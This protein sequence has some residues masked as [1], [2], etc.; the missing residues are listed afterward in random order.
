MYRIIISA[1]L[2]FAGCTS[3]V[4]EDD[5]VD[6]SVSP[7]S[8]TIEVV[9]SDCGENNG[10][11]SVDASGGTAPY[12]YILNTQVQTSN[13]FN[14]LAP[15]NYTLKVEDVNNCTFE[16][17]LQV[18]NK[19]GVIASST[20]SAAGCGTA[21]GTI[22]VS[23]SNG[24]EPYTYRFDGVSQSS[25][26]K[27][28]LEYG[29]H[30][31]VITDSDGCSF[32]LATYVPSGISYANSVGPVIM[33]SCAVAGCHNGD[34][35]LPDFRSLSNVQ[36]NAGSIRSRTQSGNMPPSSKPPLDQAEIDAIACWVDD[37]ALDN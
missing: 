37:G 6:C 30:V 23:A 18:A 7:V 27:S 1:L 35:S 17:D 33:R 32:E 16:M 4:L 3:N 22:T 28:G 34:N 12:T 11:L 36:A 13:I 25:N 19:D 8:A 2:L 10:Q 14:G 15:G 9:D 31:V 20:E 26:V 24:V 5:K 29:D 21:N